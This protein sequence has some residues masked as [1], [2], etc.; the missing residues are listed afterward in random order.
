MLLPGNVSRRAMDPG[1][2][3]PVYRQATLPGLRPRAR[4]LRYRRAV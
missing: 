2:P 1:S 3:G 4:W